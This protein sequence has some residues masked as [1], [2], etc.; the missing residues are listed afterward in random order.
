[1]TSPTLKTVENMGY[2]L[3]VAFV[4]VAFASLYFHG[5]QWLADIAISGTFLVGLP[6]LAVTIRREWRGRGR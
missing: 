1:M 3:V 2:L 6:T 4:A 5:P